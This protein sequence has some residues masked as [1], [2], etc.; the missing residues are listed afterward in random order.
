MIKKEKQ[1]TFHVVFLGESGFPR[2]LASM[3]KLI[4]ISKALIEAG[5]KVTVVNRKGKFHPNEREI[6]DAEGAFQ[7]INYIYTS[8]TVYRPEGFRNRAAPSTYGFRMGV[9]RVG[10]PGV[11]KGR[12]CLRR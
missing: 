9:R 3:N 8:G 7:N 5:A 6:I 12:R 10:T 1:S 4:L 11:R 2:G